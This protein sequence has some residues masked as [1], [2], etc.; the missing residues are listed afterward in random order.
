MLPNP[1]HHHLRDRV[2]LYITRIL[3]LRIV[4]TFPIITNPTNSISTL[5]IYCMSL[6]VYILG[7]GEFGISDTQALNASVF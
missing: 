5:N 3:T 6:Y 7:V 1:N 4:L 2:L